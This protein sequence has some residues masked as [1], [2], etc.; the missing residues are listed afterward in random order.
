M[1]LILYYVIVIPPAVFVGVILNMNTYEP[2][3]QDQ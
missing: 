3:K 2:V 1:L